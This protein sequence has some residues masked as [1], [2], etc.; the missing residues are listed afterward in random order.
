M[1]KTASASSTIDVAK[2]LSAP[3]TLGYELGAIAFA[4]MALPL[5]FIGLKV[6]A[7]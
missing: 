5:I 1:K 6:M 3:T 7:R 4:T 2:R